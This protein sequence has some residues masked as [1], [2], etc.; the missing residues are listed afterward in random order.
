[1]EGVKYGLKEKKE[2]SPWAELAPENP[3][4][5]KGPMPFVPVGT[6]YYPPLSPL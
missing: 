2:R 1:M 4:G 5:V 6:P 3:P